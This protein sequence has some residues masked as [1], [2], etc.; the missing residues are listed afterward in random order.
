MSDTIWLSKFHEERVIMTM[1]N[2][3][4]PLGT[5]QTGDSTNLFLQ[6]QKVPLPTGL[7][8]II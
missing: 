5:Q 1:T 2:A 8:Q 7:E 3:S 4:R 6:I